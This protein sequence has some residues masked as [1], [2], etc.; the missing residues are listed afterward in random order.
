MILVPIEQWQCHDCIGLPE[1]I[2]LCNS[3]HRW[4]SNCTKFGWWSI[5][6]TRSWESSSRAGPPSD[7]HH[8]GHSQ[9]AC[10]SEGHHVGSNPKSELTTTSYDEKNDNAGAHN[11]YATHRGWCSV[12]PRSYPLVLGSGSG[13][14][15][16]SEF[17]IFNPTDSMFRLRFLETEQLFKKKIKKNVLWL[18][19]PNLQ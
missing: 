7:D 4:N 8:R 5:P 18:K 15:K 19:S 16:K 12:I 11:Q 14:T 3:L 6:R 9:E 13:S 1:D 2:I 10:H 17:F